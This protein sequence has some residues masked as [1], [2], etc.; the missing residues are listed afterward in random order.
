MSLQITSRETSDEFT[1]FGRIFM[2]TYQKDY[3]DEINALWTDS[4]LL[5]GRDTYP[6]PSSVLT[7]N[8]YVSNTSH[9]SERIGLVSK[10]LIFSPPFI[11]KC[12]TSVPYLLVA[13][14][15]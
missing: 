12:F 15:V 7:Y 14:Q 2:T 1:R 8:K 5:G 6:L 10:Y 4:P 3:K 11:T 9:N 13:T